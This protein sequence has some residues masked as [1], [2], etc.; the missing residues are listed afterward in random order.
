MSYENPWLYQGKVFETENIEEYFGFVY[1]IECLE[2]NRKYLGRKYFWS[3]RTPK[4]KKRKVKQESDWKS[5]YGS[6]PELKEDIKKLGKNKFQR[7]ILSLHKTLGKTN[8]EETR[9]LFLNN[10]L[11]EA[12]D[13][14]TPR[15]YNSQI[16]GRYYKKDYFQKET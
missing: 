15:Y 10:V 6:C 2:N 16:L 7:T 3:F 8:Y 9:M 13:D 14:G 5:Y 1:L 12:L 11:S 4:G